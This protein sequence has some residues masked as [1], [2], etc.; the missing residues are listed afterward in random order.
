[1]VALP[2][3][4]E[5]TRT[6]GVYTLYSGRETFYRNPLGPWKFRDLPVH[7][8]LWA[9]GHSG[10]QD[11]GNPVAYSQGPIGILKPGRIGPLRTLFTPQM[12]FSTK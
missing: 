8:E 12:I 2:F 3:L 5:M 7:E 10:H 6:F 9:L 4:R 1:M 11:C